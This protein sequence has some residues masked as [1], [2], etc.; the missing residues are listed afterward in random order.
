M[1]LLERVFVSGSSLCYAERCIE[2]AEDVHLLI[3]S[4]ELQFPL[5][6]S[7]TDEHGSGH[8][9]LAIT[10]NDLEVYL[11]QSNGREL[12]VRSLSVF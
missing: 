6:L 5:E 12:S 4:G 2:S 8:Q 9:R 10:R 7:W 11:A 1:N 3:E